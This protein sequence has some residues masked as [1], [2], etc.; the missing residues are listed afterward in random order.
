MTR[1]KR[2]PVPARTGAKVRSR[3][4]NPAVRAGEAEPAVRSPEPRSAD[5]RQLTKSW[6][7]GVD[8]FYANS[9]LL[10][11]QLSATKGGHSIAGTVSLGRQI[12][13]S[14]NLNLAYTRLHQ[15]Y[16]NLSTLS[17]APNTNRVWLSLSYQFT[18]PIGR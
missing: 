7:A 16:G 17:A 3:S 14:L 18:R 13:Q 4:G 6:N 9:T 11:P 15:S 12:G 8:A 2:S 5:R 1:Q 10:T